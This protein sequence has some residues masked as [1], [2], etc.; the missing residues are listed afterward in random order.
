M[1]EAL[2]SDDVEA[3][4]GDTIKFGEKSFMSSLM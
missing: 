4:Y 2:H 3:A 1:R